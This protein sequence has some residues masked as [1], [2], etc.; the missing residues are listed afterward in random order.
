M[1]PK[2]SVIIPCYN[3][4][5]YLNQCLDSLVAQSLY[6]WEA[7][8]IDDGSIDASAD[9]VK[10]YQEKDSR[11]C[12]IYQTNAGASS[13]RN[14]G[15][16]NASSDLILFLDADD[17]LTPNAILEAVNYMSAHPECKMF[18]LRSAWCDEQTGE[19]RVGFCYIDYRH[20]L[21]YGQ[22]NTVVIRR[23]DFDAI[24]GFDESMKKGFEDWEFYVRLL[25]PESEVRVSDNV[26]YN[27]RV[28]CGPQNVSS[29]GELHKQEVM[30]YI[31]YKNYDK[32][33]TTLGAPQEIYQWADRRLPQSVIKIQKTYQMINNF[34]HRII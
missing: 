14:L 2:I 3:A 5:K 7:V 31:Y 18:N 20:C 16:K 23:S 28:N 26:L 29:I 25:D 4:A 8:I 19:R 22:N 12:Y 32:Y 15:V 24:G 30:K 21:V 34:I 1:T 6:E 11:L 17:W 13:A 10:Q 27:Y 33:V 9:I